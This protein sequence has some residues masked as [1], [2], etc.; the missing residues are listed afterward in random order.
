MSLE[1]VTHLMQQGFENVATNELDVLSLDLDGN[2]Y[3]FAQEL[4][5]EVFCRNFLYWNTT[6]SFR[7]QLNGPS[8]TMRTIHGI[9]Q[10]IKVLLA[11]F[12]ELLADFSYTLVCCNAATGANAF[13]VR[14]E[15]LSHFTDVPKNIDDIFIVVPIPGL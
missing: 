8:N 9:L 4:L 3:Y 7:H 15:Y 6:Q 5:K 1:N 2:D 12:S 13:F 11:L 10:I 14:N